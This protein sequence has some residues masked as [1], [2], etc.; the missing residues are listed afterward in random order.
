MLLLDD[1]AVDADGACSPILPRDFSLMMV[2]K[3][4]YL[5]LDECNAVSQR[6]IVVVVLLLVAS[7]CW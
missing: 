3:Q 1:G 6:W 7:Q 5:A 4:L 2:G